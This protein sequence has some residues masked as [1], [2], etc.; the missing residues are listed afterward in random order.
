LI[1]LDTSAL[2]ELLDGL[3]PDHLAVTRELTTDA[4]PFIVPATTLVE[5]AYLL[6]TRLQPK[7]LDAFLDDLD[8]GAFSLDCSDGDLAEVRRLVSRYADLPLGFADASV[9]VCAE[10]NGGRV[11]SLDRRDFGVVSRER[12]ITLVPA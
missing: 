7:V 12:R 6:E 4:G 5:I 9:I 1:T 10:R 2:Y 11:L 3:S 8:S